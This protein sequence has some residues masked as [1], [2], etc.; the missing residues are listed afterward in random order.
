[1]RYR[2]PRFVSDVQVRVES[3]GVQH[4]ARLVNISPSGAR[5]A[6]LHT[7]A[8]GQPVVIFHLTSQVHARVMWSNAS[9]T[10]VAFTRQLSQAEVNAIRGVGDARA[11]G[12]WSSMQLR[13][14]G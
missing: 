11:A 7:L 10:G 14:L 6:G 8:R 4:R 1:M 12:A 9:Q 13:E 3:F 2:E 5:L